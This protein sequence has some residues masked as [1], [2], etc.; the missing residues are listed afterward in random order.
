MTE[1]ATTYRDANGR[2]LT[3]A[4]DAI[5]DACGIRT[6]TAEVTAVTD[7][8]MRRTPLRPGRRPARFTPD[9][10][11]ALHDGTIRPIALGT[12][13]TLDGALAIRDAAERVLAPSATP[14]PA[15]PSHRDRERA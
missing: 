11:V 12:W 14:A 9:L 2:T 10:A 7:T 15:H 6:A 1:P 13:S 3:I 4:K 5:T 8:G